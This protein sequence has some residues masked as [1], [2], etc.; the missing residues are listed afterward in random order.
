MNAVSRSAP[1]AFAATKECTS[2]STCAGLRTF[3]ASSVNRSSLAT[4]ARNSFIGGIWMPSS[5]ISR[6]F[7]ES[8]VPPMSLTWPTVPT[9]PTSRPSRNTGVSTA[10]S[11]RWPA[12]SH[13]SL[14]T[15]TSPGSSVSGGILRQQRLHGARQAEIEHRHGARRVHQRLALGVEHLAGEI[16]RLRD[17][18]RERRAAHRQPH[19]VDHGDEPAPHDLERDRIGLDA[20]HRLGE[21]RARR[22]PA[23]AAAPRRRSRAAG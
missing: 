14:V 16:L 21:R 13:G 1:T 5:K 7:S 3:S 22:R 4:P 10:M 9:R 19:L 17:D 6:A 20:R 12:Q 11:N 23:P 2:P 18:Q 15:S 8:L